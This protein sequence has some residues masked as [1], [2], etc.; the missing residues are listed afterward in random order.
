MVSSSVGM[1]VRLLGPGL[2]QGYCLPQKMLALQFVLIF[3]K[4]QGI[5]VRIA[6]WANA[7]PCHP[8]LP[9]TVFANCEYKFS[10]LRTCM[11]CSKRVF[12]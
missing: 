7:F 3:S 8:A 11:T 1:F 4:L 5:G 10:T 12:C 9:P 6:A 2:L